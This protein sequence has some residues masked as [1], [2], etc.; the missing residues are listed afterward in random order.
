MGITLFTSVH[1][2]RLRLGPDAAQGRGTPCGVSVRLPCCCCSAPCLIAP[3]RFG[4]LSSPIPADASLEAQADAYACLLDALHIRRVSVVA[5]SAGG[6]SGLVFASRHPERT[7]ALI[8]ISAVSYT[9]PRA[10]EGR[11]QQESAINRVVGS[12]PVY[13]L[14][15]K[16]LPVEVLGLVGVPKA[17][18]QAAAPQDQALARRL[19]DEMLPMSRRMPG[20]LLDQSRDMPRDY[21]LNVR[22]PVLVVHA[23]DDTLV[24][25]SHGEH[26]AARVAGAQLL[27]LEKGGHFLL[28]AWQQ[29]RA[30][31]AAFL[32]G[33]P[34]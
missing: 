34:A 30:A 18:Y 29:A 15:A 24:P 25:M 9:E 22:A 26:S 1:G 6:P 10:A 11:V 27:L 23:R 7:K 21:P 28:G 33:L 2:C 8:M 4:Y 32:G 13:W 17:V 20:V 19:L 31:V 14:F 3:S 16:A 5:I 12:D